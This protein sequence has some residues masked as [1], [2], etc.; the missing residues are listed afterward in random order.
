MNAGA[1]RQRWRF[2]ERF[3]PFAELLPKVWNK[4]NPHFLMIFPLKESK[5]PLSY[6][7]RGFSG[8]PHFMTPEGICCALFWVL[9]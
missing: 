2:P 6:L 1:T 4:K 5:P 7:V 9:S 8:Q 3:L